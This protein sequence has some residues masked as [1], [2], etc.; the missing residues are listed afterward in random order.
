MAIGG[1][2]AAE[3]S[4]IYLDAYRTGGVEA[5]NAARAQY[6][7]AYYDTNPTIQRPAAPVTAQ[8]LQTPI[9]GNVAWGDI[10]GHVGGGSSGD[11]FSS[12]GGAGGGSSSGGSGGSLGF[13]GGNPYLPQ[14][15][16]A[17]TNQAT[18]AFNRNVLPAIGS[19]AMAA[20]GYGGSRQGV[21]EANA[22]NDLG[23]NITNSL[24]GMY[25]QAY[26]NGLQYDLGLRNNDLGFAGLDAQ[27]N[28][29][30]F[31]N[32][33]AGANF[34][35]GVWNQG[36]VNNQTGVTAGTNIQNTPMNYWSQFGNQYNGI[37]QG[38]G[39]TTGNTSQQGNPVLGALGGA[40]LGSSLANMWGGSANAAG[41]SNSQGWGTGSGY[42]N[43]DYGSFI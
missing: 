41:G 38:Y 33:L 30:N 27:I 22:M 40:Q 1:K 13:T 19:S 34:G 28:Q 7:N 23:Q 26:N 29:N 35:L 12:G 42:G 5:E 10:P 11:P 25:G 18:T 43:Q 21:V 39:S 2:T 8:D 36:M 24:A 4:E 37:G 32:N 16:D 15:A 3:W 14:M 9:F 17:L 20:G 31:N 6:A